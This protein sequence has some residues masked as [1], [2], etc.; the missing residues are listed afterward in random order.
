MT[1]PM[2]IIDLRT[3][4]P[5]RW[6]DR[7]NRRYRPSPDLV[8]RVAAIV[9]AVR[10]HGDE[11]V[12][13][14]AK[15]FDNVDLR[16]RD[17]Q[18]TASEIDQAQRQV[19]PDLLDALLNS[20]ENV[21]A[22]A[23]RTLRTGWLGKNSQGAAVG[24][25]FDPL[26]RVGI[27]VPAGTAPLVSTA[28]M[29][30]SLASAAGVPEIVVTSPVGPDKAVHPGLLTALQ[31]AGATSIYKLGGAQ[32]IAALAFGTNTI[33]SVL[34]IFGPG[35]AYV[36]EAK[37]QVFGF[38]GVD[39]LPGPSEIVVVAD[40]TA[41]AAWVAADLLAQA[42]HGA[43]SVICLVAL[44]EKVA[45]GVQK[46]IN[47]QVQ[48]LARQS[49]LRE[50]LEKQALT[51]IA[52]DRAQAAEIVNDFAPEHVS[53]AVENPDELA[54]TIKTAGAIFLG[55]L[56][57]VA[58]GDFLAGPSHELPTGGAAKFFSGLTADQF[59]RRTSIVRYDKEALEKSVPA[60]NAFSRAER[61]DAHGRSVTIR[62]E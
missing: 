57:P 21:T 16:P 17:L 60:L 30:V 24:E 19:E 42:E 23:K 41:N 29:T 18:V 2:T 32:A 33:S 14:F 26:Q 1:V 53:I 48:S 6:K 55:H 39:L 11:A 36:T 43:N 46:E 13:E 51:V 15:R 9:A 25:R 40:R 3:S 34:K 37:R 22:F 47:L 20:H 54:S 61:L 31:L 58:A 44:E 62:L 56:S 5:A 7:L 4:D 12:V 35:N 28:I 50:T 49:F 8:D 45:T 38:V 27:Y 52:K 59:Q 10:D